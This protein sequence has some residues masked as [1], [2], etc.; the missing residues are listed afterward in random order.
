MHAFQL[1]DLKCKKCRQ[2]K[3]GHMAGQCECGGS[4][5]TTTS[6]AELRLGLKVFQNIAKWHD[7]TMLEDT[8]DWLLLD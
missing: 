2:P 6:P 7:L 8:V 5:G 1:Q 3:V 4:F